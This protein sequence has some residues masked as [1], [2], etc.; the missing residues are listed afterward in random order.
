M[1]F[2]Q[3]LS[4]G[5]I[6]NI[7]QGRI[8]RGCILILLGLLLSGC[9]HVPL[10]SKLAEQDK[11]GK[12]LPLEQ[13]DV[14]VVDGE[15]AANPSRSSLFKDALH[16]YI[17]AGCMAFF[18][19][20][21]IS[22]LIRAIL[23][24]N[25]QPGRFAVRHINDEASGEN[26]RLRYKLYVKEKFEVKTHIPL[27]LPPFGVASC[28]NKTVLETS[29]WDLPAETFLGSF[30]VSAEGEYTVA[31]YLLHVA[32]SCD[33]QKDATHKLARE[34]V[35]RLTGLNPLEDGPD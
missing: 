7:L 29:L 6:L 16:N 26:E 28:G 12:V 21:T 1:I 32:T 20:D 5:C 19:D 10:S 9:I 25:P 31:A 14:I 34:L 17:T 15:N 3:V 8:W 27:Y 22:E 33:T 2:L 23:K 18:H 30:T 11:L 35:R 24:V 13:G 4:E